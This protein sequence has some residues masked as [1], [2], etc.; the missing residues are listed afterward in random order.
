MMQEK[1]GVKKQNS[2]KGSN[3]MSMLAG[4]RMFYNFWFHC[5]PIFNEGRQDSYK[6]MPVQALRIPT[7]TSRMIFWF[8]C[9][10]IFNAD[11]PDPDKPMLV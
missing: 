9:Q 6:A 1:E 2:K 3:W 5:Q 4:L 8:H 7:L 10:P 11:R